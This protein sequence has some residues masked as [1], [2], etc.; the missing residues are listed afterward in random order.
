MSPTPAPPPI[1]EVEDLHVRFSTPAG[2]V[3]AVEGVSLALAAGE[4]L[5]IV[6]ESGCGKSTL[7]RT[8]LG[9]ETPHQ[10]LIRFDG[11]EIPAAGRARRAL[12]RE[13]QLIFQDPDASL[14]PRLTIGQAV[15]EPLVI[16]Q[17]ELA[18]GAR[19][20]AVLALLGRV[21]LDPTLIDRYPH[22]L[23]GGQRQRVSIARA[24]SLKPRVLI[25]DEA[26]SALDVSI[27][28]QILNL[29]VGLQRDFGLAYLFITHDLGVV[30]YLS[31]RVA[32]MYLGQ[33]VEEAETD[34]LF[35]DPRHPYT[36]AL[37]GAVLR[38]DA[39]APRPSPG[40]SGDLPSPLHPPAGCRFQSRCRDALAHCAA[41]AP[42]HV[43]LGTRKARCFLVDPDFDQRER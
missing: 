42:A 6:G 19:R 32:V 31:H 36:K 35:D 4:T 43:Q 9:I 25:L 14:N 37:L 24:L 3:N 2:V 5:A 15:A 12:S 8:I 40:L 28:A 11:R 1:L 22:E 18:R 26:V 20:E 27:R 41:H 17:P 30:R 7:A 23:S 39:D 21:G 13:L 29:L 33:I 16:H 10:G 34:A 38:V